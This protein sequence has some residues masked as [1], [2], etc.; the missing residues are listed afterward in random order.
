MT[1]VVKLRP[2]LRPIEGGGDGGYNGAIGDLF[3]GI[4]T[5][6]ELAS[7]ANALLA[8]LEPHL[9]DEDQR[10]AFEAVERALEATTR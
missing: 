3:R 8:A 4:E 1:K 6:V 10:S 7:A 5:Y 9:L 2:R